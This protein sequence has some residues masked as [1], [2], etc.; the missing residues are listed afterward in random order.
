M[1]T[2]NDLLDKEVTTG[3]S[4][5]VRSEIAALLDIYLP[6]AKNGNVGIRYKKPVIATDESGIP[7]A[8]DNTK[9]EAVSINLVFEFDRVLDIPKE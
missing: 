6:V 4:D 8:F 1:E 2:T 3:W 7:V 5:Y 9:A